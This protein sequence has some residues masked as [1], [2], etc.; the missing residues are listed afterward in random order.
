MAC[1]AGTGDRAAVEDIV[2]AAAAEDVPSLTL[3]S[4]VPNATSGYDAMEAWEIM[5]LLH[6]D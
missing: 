2:L 6:A 5:M 4:A 3:D 1:W